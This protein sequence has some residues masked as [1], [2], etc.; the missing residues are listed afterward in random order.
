MDLQNLNS[1]LK[2]EIF[3]HENQSKSQTDELKKLRL[4]NIERS[5]T[6]NVKS[7]VYNHES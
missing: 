3:R 7:E 4:N 2:I 6:Q 1:K 5:N